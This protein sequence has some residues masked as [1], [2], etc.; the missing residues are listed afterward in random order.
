MR[1]RYNVMVSA[2]VAAAALSG[3]RTALAQGSSQPAAISPA[4]AAHPQVAASVGNESLF[5]PPSVLGESWARALQAVID[6]MK[7]SVDA[8]R[9]EAA[10][11]LSAPYGTARPR[12]RQFTL[13]RSPWMPGEALREAIAATPLLTP[14]TI[15]PAT[16]SGV[17]TRGEHATL[18]GV[19]MEM[20]WRVPRGRGT[21]SG[22]PQV[23]SRNALGRSAG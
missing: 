6:E 9:L 8:E 5:T 15:E 11:A 23:E 3:A 20:P 1:V 19:T 21:L 13:A 2:I 22:V 14:V 7:Q 16:E 17:D 4:L 12:A 18:V 10:E